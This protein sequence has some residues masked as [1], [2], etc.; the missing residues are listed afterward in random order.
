VTGRTARTLD[1]QATNEN[2]R[3]LVMQSKKWFRSLRGLAIVLA[4]G[5]PMTMAVSHDAYAAKP[6]KSAKKGKKK[7]GDDEGGSYQAPYGMAGCGL[8]SV[9]IK[10]D[11]KFP[12]ITAATL[13]GTGYQTSAISC[14][15]SSNCKKEDKDTA[16]MEQAVFVAANLRALEVD[17]SS[18]GGE[19]THAFAQ[20]LGCTGEGQYDRFLEMSRTNYST[21][22]SSSDPQE[23]YENY[24][25]V[26][27]AEG[28]LAADCERVYLKT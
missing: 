13:N 22:F 7:G 10:S 19:Y 3:T 2:R 8:G 16:Q 15:H 6:K 4:C 25:H 20:V 26:L 23:V 11:T 17:V 12:Q 27:R 21:I 9:V 18:G 14:S 1:F 5:L 28:K 24:L